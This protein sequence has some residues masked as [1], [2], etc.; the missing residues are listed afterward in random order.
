MP[1]A[2]QYCPAG[3]ADVC[4]VFLQT[5]RNLEFVGK[6]ILAKAM[7]VAA[8]CPFLRRSVRQ[9][10]LRP[11]CSTACEQKGEKTKSANHDVLTNDS[12]EE[13]RAT[14]TIQWNRA[15]LRLEIKV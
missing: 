10:A 8:T 14:V 13:L 2:L 7:R 11:G 5:G 6:D 9:T 12:A 1:V 15:V 4:T 3:V